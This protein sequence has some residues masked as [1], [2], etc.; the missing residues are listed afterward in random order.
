M[1]ARTLQ[2]LFFL[3]IFLQITSG[4]CAAM[5]DADNSV[6][7]FNMSDMIRRVLMTTNFC[8][9]EQYLRSEACM[10]HIFKE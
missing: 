10:L 4:L 9:A 8:Y 7:S 1:G 6:N 2:I 5:S 3:T